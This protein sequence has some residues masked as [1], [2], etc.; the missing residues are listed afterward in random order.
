[1][2]NPDRRSAKLL[3]NGNRLMK[4]NLYLLI[5]LL[6][7][8]LI[9]LIG[10]VETSEMTMLAAQLPRFRTLTTLAENQVEVVATLPDRPGNLAVTPDGRIILSLHPFGQPKY[11][12][13]ELLQDGSTQPFPSPEWE[14]SPDANGIGFDEVIGIEADRN[15]VVWML[16]KGVNGSIPRLIAWDTQKDA[17]VQIIPIPTPAFKPNSF[18]QDL[19][20]DLDHQAVYIADMSRGDLVGVSDPAIVVVDLKTGT[21]RRAL[22]NHP[23]LQADG[24]NFFI[25]GKAQT[26][27]NDEGEQVRLALGLNPITIDSKNEWVYYGAMNGRSL[28]R[29]GT[30]D[31]RNPNLSPQQIAM[32]V[33]RYGQKTACDGISID[34][35]GNVYVTDVNANAI[36]VTTPGGNY[37]VLY[38]DSRLSWVDGL[39]YAPDGYFYATVNQLH[40]H[41][42][43]NGGQ[44]A[45]KPPYLIVRFKPIAPGTVGR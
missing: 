7:A 41:P 27:S 25:D 12:V 43:L 38:Q 26:V 6:V 39:S 16:D 15:G 18:M 30:G 31:L 29:I 4:P 32:R 1:M 5:S 45:S 2:Q 23:S 33:E 34:N 11:K 22:E 21:T 28:Y 10:S 13:V 20:I 36:G 9:N 37:R 40:R 35:A 3:W 19:A 14:Q 24:A 44:D 8:L 42:V 17:L